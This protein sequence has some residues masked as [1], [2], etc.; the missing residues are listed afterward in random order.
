MTGGPWFVRAV[1][2]GGTHRAEAEYWTADG[3]VRIRPVCD[4]TTVFTALN[5]EPVAVPYYDEQRCPV[6]LAAAPEPRTTRPRH[7]AVV[8]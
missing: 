3:R 4:S 5:R 6:C 7:L 8:R 2:D 1:E